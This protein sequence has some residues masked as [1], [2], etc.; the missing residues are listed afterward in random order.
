M[1][2]W[3]LDKELHSVALD[4]TYFEFQ[5]QLLPFALWPRRSLANRKKSFLII[6]FSVQDVIGTKS[7]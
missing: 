7:A 2:A 4:E 3:D 1:L 5:Q 6:F